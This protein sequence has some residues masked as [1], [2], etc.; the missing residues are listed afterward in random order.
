MSCVLF[1]HSFHRAPSPGPAWPPQH[2]MAAAPPVHTS[3]LKASSTFT[4]PRASHTGLSLL[5]ASACCARG[6][7][8]RPRTSTLPRT[9]P[10]QRHPAQ[11]RGGPVRALPGAPHPLP[12]S[13][14][15]T[16][17]LP[18]LPAPLQPCAADP[19][20]TAAL[21][22]PSCSS[23]LLQHPTP[24]VTPGHLAPCVGPPGPPTSSLLAAP[25]PP[26][27]ILG[28]QASGPQTSTRLTSAPV[29]R[30]SKSISS[31]SNHGATS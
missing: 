11:Y 2:S 27:S 1:S 4:P 18:P 13:L 23:L 3:D 7:P 8:G 26:P 28:T 31:A 19:S 25:S 21:R 14:P 10:R 16:L 6:G 15:C 22:D 17:T 29:S 20:A 12:L 9:A 24:D 5:E 30:V